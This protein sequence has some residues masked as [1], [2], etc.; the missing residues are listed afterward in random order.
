[1]GFDDI[2]G[3]Q[4]QLA[5][6]RAALGNGRLHHAYLFLG[7]E[8]VGKRL[9]ALALAKALHCIEGQNNYCGGCV[10][11]RRIDDRNHPDVRLI[12]AASA[13]K[14]IS[15]QQVRELERELNYRSF[16][17]KRKIAIIDPA[18]SLNL[19]S[20]NALLK[21]L[22]EPPQNSLIMLIA[23]NEG[24]LLPTLRSRCLR[25][26]FAPLPRQEIARYLRA[27]DGMGEAE[28]ECLAALS[29][30][31]MG[32]GVALKNA[33]LSEKRKT[34]TGMLGAFK[35]RDYRSAMMAAEALAANR[36][37]TIEFLNWAESW[38]RDLVI[39]K[40]AQTT[41]EC[42]NLD[43]QQELERQ[44]AQIKIEPALG[45]LERI[46]T[47]RTEIQRNLNRRMV[48]EKFLFGIVEER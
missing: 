44:T 33:D 40:L 12:E 47:A 17:G 41:D 26:S 38:Y 30:G 11:C 24:G 21:T 34:W 19:P 39:A 22:E 4:K 10:N 27:R 6:L 43:M 14:E 3:Q 25:L 7:P 5:T 28:A 9:T 46:A 13:K 16:T 36:D 29:M 37:E 20:Q 8:G 23:V 35:K 32:A 45:A 48:L 15:I 31:S 42:V 1:M 2:I 18:T